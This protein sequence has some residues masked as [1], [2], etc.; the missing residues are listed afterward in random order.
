MEKRPNPVIR[1]YNFFIQLVH[2]PQKDLKLFME[3]FEHINS[4]NI[5]KK[6]NS[7]STDNLI[8]HKDTF[9]EDTIINAIYSTLEN[10]EAHIQQITELRQRISLKVC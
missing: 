4:P 3:Q 6:T 9:N 10:H 1:K 2:R 7:H 5:P 8:G